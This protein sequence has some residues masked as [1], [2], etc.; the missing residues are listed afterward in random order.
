MKIRLSVLVILIHV[1]LAFSQIPQNIIFGAFKNENFADSILKRIASTGE[2]STRVKLF[3][4]LGMIYSL[5]RQDSSIFYTS[6]AIELA[7][8][9]DFQPGRY[10]GYVNLAFVLNTSGNYG[11]GL[12]MAIKSLKIAEKLPDFR[13]I[14]MA[15]SY[16]MM[17]LINRRMNND[18][19]AISQCN[20]A[21][22]LL[23]EAGLGLGNEKMNFSPYLDLSLC[24]LKKKNL[25][26]A[27]YYAKKCYDITTYYIGRDRVEISVSASTVAN[28]YEQMGNFPLART[29]YQIAIEAESNFNTPLL[30][31]R[32]Y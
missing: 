23:D 15:R 13:L 3:N 29:Y 18:S 6:R 16:D 32:I 1:H 8:K 7:E 11:K 19:I 31:V 2:D 9:I 20:R 12:E 22:Q 14:R 24:F 10:F 26:S 4:D 25:D 27:F 30:R 17:G 28:V 21:I 5:I